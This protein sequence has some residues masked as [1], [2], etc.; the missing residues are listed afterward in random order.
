L[1]NVSKSTAMAKSPLIT[2]EIRL[3]SESPTQK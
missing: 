3:Q 2:A 1:K